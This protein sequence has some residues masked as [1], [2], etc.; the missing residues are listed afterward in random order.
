MKAINQILIGVYFL[1]FVSS[2]GNIQK[3][4]IYNNRYNKVDTL[5]IGYSDTLIIGK[6]L[7]PTKVSKELLNDSVLLLFQVKNNYYA[8]YNSKKKDDFLSSFYW[9][10]LMSKYLDFSVE[11][12]L[13][14]YSRFIKVDYYDPFLTGFY[15]S[16]DSIITSKFDLKAIDS[17]DLFHVKYFSTTDTLL[18]VNKNISVGKSV[19][20]VLFELKIPNTF[21]PKRDFELVLMKATTQID[22]AWYNDFPEY[23]SDYSVTVILSVKNSKLSRI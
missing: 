10:Q 15:N 20:E 21:N 9:D 3:N 1:F 5:K 23:S 22:N 11:D 18:M 19:D 14:S 12:S 8:F 2:C 4:R 7:F 16:R 17:Q 13:L 6:Q